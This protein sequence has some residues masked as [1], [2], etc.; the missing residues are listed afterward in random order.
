MDIQ[1]DLFDK[2]VK[3]ILLYGSEIWGLGNLDVIEQVQLKFYKHIF[4]LKSS[5]PNYMVY[6]ELGV[7]P[8]K[9]Y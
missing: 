2:T 7:F 1:I 5:T 3:P 6:G 9:I 8:V 4:G